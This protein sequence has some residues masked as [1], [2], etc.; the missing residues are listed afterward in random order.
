METSGQFMSPI[1]QAEILPFETAERPIV[2]YSRDYPS[3]LSTGFHAHPRAQ[4]VYA[5][6]GVMRVETR[7]SNYIVAPTTALLL[8]ADLE[9]AVRMDGPVAM[10]ELFLREE[11]T[12]RL[13]TRSRVIVV[14]PLLRE[15]I[16]AVCAEPVDWKPDGRGYHLAELVISEIELSTTMPLGLP[17]PKDSRL[18][19]VVSALRNRPHD[20]R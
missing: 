2:G 7:T 14:S 16:V 17:L 19:R 1:R 13:G 12:D 18:R 11:A 5:I 3:G 8:P 20:N 6:S 15:L 4:L 9:H 10:R